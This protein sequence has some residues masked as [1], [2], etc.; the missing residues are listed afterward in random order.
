V[1]LT[2][3]EF[4][5]VLKNEIQLSRE[6]KQGLI[7]NKILYLAG[8]YNRDLQRSEEWQERERR[9]RLQSISIGE[10]V[11]V[12]EKFG[13]RYLIVKTFKLFP[14]V[15]DDID[16]LLLDFNQRDLLIKELLQRGYFIRKVG[17][18]EITLRKVANNTYVDLDIHHKMAAGNYVYYDSE[19]LWRNRRKMHLNDY[20][21]YTTSQQDECIL[22]IAHAL[23]KEFEI[24]LSDFL[25]VYLCVKLNYM[26]TRYLAVVGHRRT[27]E[28]FSHKIKYILSNEIALPYRLHVWEAVDIYLHNVRQRIKKDQMK[29]LIELISSLESKGLAKIFTIRI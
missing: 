10:V 15:P 16:I 6:I 17:T 1:S 29:V 28:L 14:Y 2:L 3:T 11:E 4:I 23:M 19:I 13:I 21:V 22:T 8:L 5:K 18:P 7:A 9:R 12:A 26:D 27:F 24:L 25:Q 20:E